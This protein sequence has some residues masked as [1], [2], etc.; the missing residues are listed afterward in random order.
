M[1]I[2]NKGQVCQKSPGKLCDPCNP[3]KPEC[4]GSGSQCVVTNAHETY[5]GTLCS[6]HLDCPAG[7][8]CMTVKLKQ[9]S[10]RQCIP[11][12]YSCYY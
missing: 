4:T 1:A 5:C 2:G 9:G 7:Y 6:T 12:D 10:T 8:G 3:A 11:K